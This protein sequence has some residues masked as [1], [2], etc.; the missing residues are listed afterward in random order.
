MV[1][2]RPDGGRIACA[3]GTSAVPEGQLLFVPW[4]F[5]LAIECFTGQYADYQAVDA[6]YHDFEHTLQAHAVH[7]PFAAGTPL[8][9][10]PT[11]LSERLFQ[12]GISAF[13]CM[14]RA[15]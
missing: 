11:A 15:I 7:G 14:T 9:Q 6:R 5:G 2:K 4:V 1:A 13:C 3:S 8:R 12:L 10:R